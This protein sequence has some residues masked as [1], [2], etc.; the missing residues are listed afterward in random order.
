MLLIVIHSPHCSI[1][2]P[3]EFTDQHISRSDPKSPGPET[4]TC[5]RQTQ[6]VIQRYTPYIGRTQA[7]SKHAT[8]SRQQCTRVQMSSIRPL[9][10]QLHSR[11]NSFGL[12]YRASQQTS[13]PPAG[14]TKSVK[15]LRANLAGG[16]NGPR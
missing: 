6:P 5:R 10:P 9:R 4:L 13:K 14:R 16:E 15:Q 7:Q 12:T 2:T 3:A 1:N 8:H 11:S